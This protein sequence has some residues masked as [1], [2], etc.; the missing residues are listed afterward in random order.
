MSATLAPSAAAEGQRT[1]IVA[2]LMATYLQAITISLP[3]AALL[4]IQGAL[5]MSDDEVGW[6]FTSYITASATTMTMARWLAGR[7]GQKS[8]FQIS[9]VLFALGLVLATR[10][11]TPMQFIAARVVQG[12]ASGTLAPL[13]IAILLD[14]LPPSRHA[15][16]NLVAAVT[17][18]L[19][20]LSGPTVGGWLSE[21]HDW[22]SMFYV[23]LPVTGFIF[24][25]MALSLP[26]KRSAQ[27]QPFDFFGLTTFSI[28]AVALQT[29]LDRGERM[30]WFELSRDLG[31]GDCL[32]AGFHPLYRARPDHQGA[33][34]R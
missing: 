19:G 9:I 25:A 18:M 26:E 29:L 2:A 34:P 8:V 32:G 12:G 24:L 1:I 31:R 6:I 16:I 33:F 28:G 15:R 13:S 11:T 20:L 10:A 4:Y 7:Y 14:I 21:Y 22:R 27:N 17:L 5:S 23:G 30:E 3:N